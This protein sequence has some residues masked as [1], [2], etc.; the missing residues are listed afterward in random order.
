M[1]E[2]PYSTSI[3]YYRSYWE[4]TNRL[5]VIC[6]PSSVEIKI[7]ILRSQYLCDYVSCNFNIDSKINNV[8]NKY[9]TNIIA[10]HQPWV[11]YSSCK[12]YPC[13]EFAMYVRVFFYRY[14]RLISD[15]NDFYLIIYLVSLLF[16][17]YITIV[18]CCY[19]NSGVTQDI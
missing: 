19:S 7:D 9:I 8:S 12:E 17:T 18:I 15:I 11:V 5:N 6:R 16:F 14:A 1:K 4:N 13:C 2:E 3:N 10:I